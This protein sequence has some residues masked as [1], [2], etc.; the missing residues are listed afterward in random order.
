MRKRYYI[1]GASLLA[2]LFIYLFFRTE[3]TVINDLAIRLISFGNYAALKAY[4]Q[5][6]VILNDWMVYSLPEG[7]WVFCITLISKPYVV[8]YKSLEIEGVMVPI[9]FCIGLEFLQLLQW[10]NGRFD[11]AD[12]WTSVIFWFLAAYAFKEKCG[13]QNI[14]ATL[15]ARSIMCFFTYGIIYLS[16]VLK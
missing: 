5:R 14:L 9:I 11:P 12:I 2:S 13:K 16:H 15:N 6:T 4:V 3:K 1:V 7:L 10:T 8:G